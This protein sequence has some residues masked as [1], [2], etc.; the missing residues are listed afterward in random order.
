[1]SQ[2]GEVV[3]LRNAAL[4]EQGAHPGI[5][6]VFEGVEPEG[7]LLEDSAGV[8]EVKDEEEDYVL[9]VV[10]GEHIVQEEHIGP[11]LDEVELQAGLVAFEVGEEV[12]VLVLGFP[13]EETDY[14]LLACPCVS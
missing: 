7:G 11:A 5:D 3:T 2:L 14:A 4:L 10:R 6:G 8:L 1:M 13:L 9:V 12:I